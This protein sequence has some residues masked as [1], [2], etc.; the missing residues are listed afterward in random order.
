MIN[1]DDYEKRLIL[2]L[3]EELR[4]PVPKNLCPTFYNTLTYEGDCKIK[5]KA[6]KLAEKLI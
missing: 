2:N 3:I 6:D 4:K 5:Q 1:L